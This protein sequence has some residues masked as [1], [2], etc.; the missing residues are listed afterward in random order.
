[1]PVQWVKAELWLLHRR[2]LGKFSQQ[3]PRL[4]VADVT[5]C[6]HSSYLSWHFQR[7]GCVIPVLLQGFH[8]SCVYICHKSAYLFPLELLAEEKRQGGKGKC[9]FHKPLY[10]YVHW[11]LKDQDHPGVTQK[12]T[13]VV[14]PWA[15]RKQPTLVILSSS[16]SQR[17]ACYGH[18]PSLSFYKSSQMDISFKTLL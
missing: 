18:A 7:C 10:F 3:Q 5:S 17:T 16:S 1:M 4:H 6:P 9:I 2:G 12:N 15:L 11:L 14:P 13:V 8:C